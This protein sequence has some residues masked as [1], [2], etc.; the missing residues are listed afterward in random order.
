LVKVRD[1][2]T[3]VYL[4][5]AERRAQR[6]ELENSQVTLPEA[7]W[8]AYVLSFI[9]ADERLILKFPADKDFENFAG[10][11]G[12]QMTDLET[13]CATTDTHSF[14]N[15]RRNLCTGP[16]AKRLLDFNKPVAPAK[17][18]F[19]KPDPK[20]PG[21][22]KDKPPNQ[23][24]PPRNQPIREKPKALTGDALKKVD[25]PAAIPQKNCK[26][27]QGKYDLYPEGALRKRLWDRMQE[28]NA[29]DAEVTNTYAPLVLTRD[30][31]GKT[32]STLDRLSGERK[33]LQSKHALSGPPVQHFCQF[34]PTMA[35]LP[36]TH[37]PMSR[38]VLGNVSRM[39]DLVPQC[40]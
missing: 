4:C 27:D 29:F 11:A 20:E 40:S 38:P 15:F 2:G 28:K 32:T 9:S 24:K 31:S 19:E 25:L 16:L 13:S 12:Y 36:S 1:E 17:K 10:G 34:S 21:P 14:K 33:H 6:Q 23:P 8:L 3:P 35:R 37:V 39:S 5:I 18:P 26:P 7:I 30:M 22:K